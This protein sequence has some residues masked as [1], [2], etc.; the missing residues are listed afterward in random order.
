M[1]DWWW[2]YVRFWVKLAIKLFYRRIEIHGTDTYP[3][4]GPVFLA[5]NHQNAFMDA[6]IP[7]V[8]ARKP[9]HFLARADV[10]NKPLLAALLRSFYMMPVYRQ[11]DGVASLAKNEEIFQRCFEILQS[12][13][14]LLIFPEATHLGER[15]L[16]PLSKGFTRILFGALEDHDDL[17][18]QVV[19]VG[20]NYEHYHKSGS[21]LIMNYGK[22]IA[23][24]AYRE[25]YRQNAPRAMASLRMAVQE[26]LAEEMVHLERKDANGAFEVEIERIIPYYLHRAEGFSQGGSAEMDFYKRRESQLMALPEG[27]AYFRRISIYG[28]IMETRGLHAPFFD[29]ERK[30]AGY[31][32]VQTLLLLLALPLFALSWIFMA[33]SY[34]LVRAV[35]TKYIAD[36]QF[37]SSIKLVAHLILF[38]LFGL[39]YAIIAALLSAK[40][41]LAALAVLAFYPLCVFII[42]ELRI[43]YRRI[44]TFGR[45]R[46]I[47]WR[48][49]ELYKYLREI[50]ADL[51]L[52][53]RR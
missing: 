42:R 12:E 15:R 9:V 52:A 47:K 39:V 24:S 26:A 30:D 11:R 27:H 41:L 46:W 5:P 13:G 32:V 53:Y 35:L 20:I 6:L 48:H 49:H 43:P 3:Q 38:P 40:P 7:A 21:R 25:A 4:S 10:F 51:I 2:Y 1:K 31:W 19:P 29:M 37:W 44:L 22:P 33:P 16:R 28:S 50:E 45:M 8:F 36:K 34:L 18:I 23:V 17:H 14:T